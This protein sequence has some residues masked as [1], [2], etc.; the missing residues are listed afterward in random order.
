MLRIR[1]FGERLSRTNKIKVGVA[2]ASSAAALSG[3]LVWGGGLAG[4]AVGGPNCHVPADYSTI[5][6]AV[7]DAGCETIKVAAGA[8]SENVVVDR[9][10][11]L[12][13]AKAGKDATSR[14]FPSAGESTVTGANPA[15]AVFSVE[16][17]DV[18]IDGFAVT[19]PGGGLG[20]IVKVAGDGAFLK[21]NIVDTVGGAAFSGPTVGIYLEQGPDDVGIVRNKVAH[22]QSGPTGSAQGV[23]VGDSVSTDPSLDIYIAKNLFTDFTSG[24]RGA[25]GV[26]VNNGASTVPAATGYATVE[27]LKNKIQNLSGSWVHAIGLEGDTP[28]AVVRENTVSNITDVTPVSGVHDAVGVFLEA[29]PSYLTVEVNYNNFNVSDDAY[30]I[31]VHPTLAAVA[32]NASVDGECNWWNDKT[33]PSA[34]G[35]GSGAHVGPNVDYKPWLVSREGKCKG[36]VATERWQCRNDGWQNL[37]DAEGDPFKNQG[38]CLRFV[39]DEDHDDYGHGHWN[40]DWDWDRR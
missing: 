1:R 9:S 40:K 17:E 38:Q 33:G 29:N 11:V 39:E 2:A 18:T 30:G 34:V 5:Q 15:L 31:A 3:L 6:A 37:T 35:T 27:I 19:N 12:K 28:D 21:N 10:V 20:V 16:A 13:G 7:D 36:G 14:S 22:V 8:Y 23:L 32:P 4:A 26:Q 25:Y 24:T